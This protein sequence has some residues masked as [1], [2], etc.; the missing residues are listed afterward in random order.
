[1]G[2]PEFYSRPPFLSVHAGAVEELCLVRDVRRKR[3]ASLLAP[4]G[5]H[6]AL[7]LDAAVVQPALTAWARQAHLGPSGVPRRGA[8]SAIR[9]R[10]LRA[11]LHVAAAQRI[12]VSGA[13][14]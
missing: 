3:C 13:T 10:V 7:P 11:I 1:M 6:A 4:F 8:G 12:V 14:R 9:M 2:V 5:P